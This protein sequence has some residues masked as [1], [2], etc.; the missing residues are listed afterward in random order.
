M[1]EREERESARAREREKKREKKREGEQERGIAR[2]KKKNR[3]AQHHHPPFSLLASDPEAFKE[4]V[5]DSL[6]RQAT[7]INRLADYG[8]FFWDY[9]NAF[10]LE[11]KSEIE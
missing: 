1:S 10:L 3:K 11:G 6:R 9:G 8:M 5:E 7:A 2:M 4:M